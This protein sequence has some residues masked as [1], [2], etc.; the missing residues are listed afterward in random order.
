M[1]H[2][3]LLSTPSLLKLNPF[4]I[5]QTL[6]KLISSS[7]S[8]RTQIPDFWCPLKLTD[9]DGSIKT[10]ELPK[11]RYDF[12]LQNSAGL[13]FEAE[14]VRRMISQGLIE[15]PSVTHDESLRIVRVQ[16]KLRQLLRV[17]FPEDDLE[18]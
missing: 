2:I 16:D 8:H 3:F 5:Q 4:F 14:E 17:H 7:C 10:W 11:A 18:Y 1:L 6:T 15:S 12:L 9:V 13:S